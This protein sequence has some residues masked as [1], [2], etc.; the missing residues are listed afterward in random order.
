MRSLTAQQ[1]TVSLFTGLT[2]AESTTARDGTR[3]E[4]PPHRSD[5]ARPLLR[6]APNAGRLAAWRSSPIG[7]VIEL[8]RGRYVLRREAGQVIGRYETV[9]AAANAAEEAR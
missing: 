7:F 1:R 3:A 6:W 2:D 8:K 5:G 4:P 9:I